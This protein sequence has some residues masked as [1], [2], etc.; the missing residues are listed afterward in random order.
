MRELITL[1]E[2]QSKP[3]DVELIK[4]NYTST[5]LQPV[6]SSNSMNYHYGKLAAGYAERFNSGEGDRDFN[7]AGLI[8][9]N[10]LFTQFRAPRPRNEPNGP[11]GN[12]IKSR[13]GSFDNF[14]E[15]FAVEAM[16]LQGSGWVYLARDGTIK[17]IRNHALRSDILALVDLWEHA[18]NI[19]YGANKK[20]YLEN[21]WKIFDW[22]V[23]N[24]R[25]GQAYK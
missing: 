14:K 17:T 4:L 12:L 7:Y 22:N 3:S 5:A 2:A 20:K 25:W 19:D 6:L 16:K 1:L 21:I 23:I 18:F 9:H 15:K 11:I 24:T 8:L 10:L 13:F